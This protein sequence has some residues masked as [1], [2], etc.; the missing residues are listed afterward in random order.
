MKINQI[1][2][3]LPVKDVEKTREFWTKI[4]FSIN[5]QITDEKAVC[6]DE[7]QYSDHVFAG[8]I[9]PDIF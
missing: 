3:N 1:Y 2:V 8:R 7:R 6:D 4:G 9:F 5:E